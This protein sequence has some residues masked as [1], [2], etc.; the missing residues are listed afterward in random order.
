MLLVI[1]YVECLGISLLQTSIA[2]TMISVKQHNE[3]NQ[4]LV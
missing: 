3:Q 4:K 1:I 2:G